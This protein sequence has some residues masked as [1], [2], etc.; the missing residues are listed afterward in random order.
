MKTYRA[1]IPAWAPGIDAWPVIAALVLAVAL[2]VALPLYGPQLTAIPVLGILVLAAVFAWPLAGMLATVTL[3]STIFTYGALPRVGP[4]G[5]SLYLPEIFLLVLLLWT[6]TRTNEPATAARESGLPLAD[7]AFIGLIASATLSVAISWLVRGESISANLTQARWVVLYALY[8]I[9]RR[10]LK[11]GRA[12]KRIILA[13]FAIGAVTAVVF[14]LMVLTNLRDVMSA[15]SWFAVESHDLYVS[16][17][18]DSI[19]GARIYMPGR[20]L[21]QVLLLPALIGMIVG[22]PGWFRR[23]S[24][25]LTLL[26]GVTVVLIFTR[27]VWVTTLIS[28]ALLAVLLSQT[29]RVNL[30]KIAGWVVATML[31]ATAVLTVSSFGSAASALDTIS[32]RFGTV[33]SDNIQDQDAQYRFTE[34]Q[35]TLARVSDSWLFGSG[36]LATVQAIPT[37]DSVTGEPIIEEVG[38]GHN[39][40]LSLLLNTGVIGLAFFVLLCGL[41][42]RATWA[43][44]TRQPSQ[45]W[46]TWA[47]T[48]G[49]ALTLI[50]ILLNGI[51]ES[52]FS[53]SFTVPLMA[54]AYALVERGLAGDV[55]T[56]GLVADS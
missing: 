15:Y 40:Y 9:T 16:A 32:Q 52:T 14:D 41:I 11:D 24:F 45:D 50:R 39:G 26:F 25:L 46:F 17:T 21:V 37:V 56:G 27:M 47:M 7:V 38:T 33:F 54:V 51:S 35:A 23:I 3:V 53:D 20:A 49:F 42:V 36:F 48:L 34:A 1:P 4:S 55:G 6:L 10:L 30:L 18:A 43:A 5:V 19:R 13:L 2:G 29:H 44:R 28:V 8:F 31:L 22:P 12:F